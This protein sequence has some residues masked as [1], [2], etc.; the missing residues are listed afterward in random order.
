MA[1]CPGNPSEACAGSPSLPYRK[2][3][4]QLYTLS[5]VAIYQVVAAPVAI[6]STSSISGTSS[7]STNNVSNALSTSTVY[8]TETITITSCAPAITNCPA[9]TYTTSAPTAIVVYSEEVASNSTTMV[10]ITTMSWAPYMTVPGAGIT[11]TGGFALP[12]V[13]PTYPYPSHSAMSAAFR[14]GISLA[15]SSAA[16]LGS[17]VLAVFWL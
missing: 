10:P 13:W 5:P 15:W 8:D 6:S 7:M 3:G 1:P 12:T 9:R 14:S 2:R 4:E 17:M 11:P 16:F